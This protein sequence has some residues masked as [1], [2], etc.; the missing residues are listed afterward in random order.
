MK[1]V[2]FENVAY[3][4]EPSPVVAESRAVA[5]IRLHSAWL[6]VDVNGF[7]YRV[8]FSEFVSDNGKP[9][10]YVCNCRYMSQRS[11]HVFS[12]TS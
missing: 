6:R 8:R 12:H 11:G 9:T 4:F 10:V 7:Y 2:K 5:F 3:D 1:Y